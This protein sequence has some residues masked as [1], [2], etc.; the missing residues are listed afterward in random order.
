VS[1]DERL[2]IFVVNSDNAVYFKRQTIAGS[3][4]WTGWTYLGASVRLDADIEA[5]KNLDGRL[6]AFVVNNDNAVYYKGQ[7]TN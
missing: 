2:G 3:D 6:A 5:G 7:A 1:D 4:T